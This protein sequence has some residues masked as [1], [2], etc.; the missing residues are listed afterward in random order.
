MR[1]ALGLAVGIALAA[2]AGVADAGGIAPPPLPGIGGHD[3]RVRVD[4]DK[5]PWRAVGRLHAVSGGLTLS[6]TGTL[7][8]PRVVLTA[9]HCVF[10]PRTRRYFSPSSVHFLIGF[11]GDHYA[12]H[13]VGAR[14]VT[15]AGYDPAQPRATM[16]S[17]WAL[18]T[19]DAP[20]GTPD[21]VLAIRDQ[22]PAI[23]AMAAMGG[24]SQDHPLILTAD[25]ACRVVGRAVDGGG[26]PLLRH[27]CTATHGTSGAPLLIEDDGV[28]SVGGI[29]VA[30]EIGVAS[31]VAALLDEVRG[32]F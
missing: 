10:N 20:L 13:A 14:L 27:N 31:G 30:A 19:I 21:R 6:C 7:V 28:W 4:P 17:D 5:A 1:G 26:R 32:K 18:L 15:G 3:P 2:V 12:G 16:A 24:Y 11:A 23:G 9:A 22:A 8:A 25:A 29:N